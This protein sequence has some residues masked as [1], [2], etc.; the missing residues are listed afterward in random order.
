MLG[1]PASADILFVVSQPDSQYGFCTGC[2]SDA[3]IDANESCVESGGT[4]CQPVL[5]C[6]NGWSATA[7]GRVDGAPAAVGIICGG[8][9]GV[10]ASIYAWAFC[11]AALNRYCVGEWVVSPSN[12]IRDAAE[13]RAYDTFLMQAMLGR[14]GY[15]AG[16]VD[17]IEGP[18][19]ISAL[20]QFRQKMG[21]EES[22]SFVAEDAWKVAMAFGG[23]QRLID[24]LRDGFV[25]PQSEALQDQIYVS[26][27]VPQPR[28][29]FGDELATY[30]DG[31]RRLALT[32]FLRAQ[33]HPCGNIA[34]SAV[35]PFTGDNTYWKV[36]CAEADYDLFLQADGT[37]VINATP[38]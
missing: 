5:A 21:L 28:Q 14:M 9:D 3:A 25:T 6:G 31:D 18:Q 19:T 36:T 8:D 7:R 22:N 12:D 2:G 33:G 10:L 1:G 26:A 23:N 29:S 17:G 30:D 15:P 38:K 13:G 35:A 32:L 20:N 11:T 4:L 34:E 37:T 24:E 27:P 16:I